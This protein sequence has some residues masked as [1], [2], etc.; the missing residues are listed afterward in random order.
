MLA[1]F[2]RSRRSLNR[3]GFGR[4]IAG[5]LVAGSL[6]AAWLVWFL[7]VPV[8][9]Y[10][11]TEEARIEADSSTHVLQAPVAGRVVLSNL[12]LG[13]E[14]EAGDILVAIETDMQRLQVKEE[15]ARAAM[16]EAEWRAVRAQLASE[17]QSARAETTVSMAAVGESRAQ[18]REAEAQRAFA[19]QEAER[20]S[21]LRQQ[22]LVAKRE[23]E[24]VAAGARSRRAAAEALTLATVRLEREQRRAESERETIMTRLRGES[25]RLQA[26]RV[27][28]LHTIE[29]LR[30][31][32]SRRNI[33]APVPGRLGE[34][35]V[36]RVGAFVSEGETLG[37]VVPRGRLRIVAQFTP[38][39]A[40]G[41]IRPGQSAWM[42]LAGFP[43]TQYGALRA[44]VQRVGHEVR[45]G[46]VRVELTVDAGGGT[47]APLQHGLPGTVE[48]QTE[49]VT[50]A[51]L[52]LRTAGRLIDR[53][54]TQYQ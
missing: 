24:R 45:N 40:L 51:T 4:S 32:V 39:A 19:D 47:A 48:V 22:G 44:T 36:L 41:R 37:A 29:R 8:A 20:T 43:W 2:G 15:E 16:L 21:R 46:R 31:E 28:A 30:F 42:R 1:E 35:G 33:V 9:R 25:D 54:R 3:D 49:T 6:L 34:V 13:R 7:T 27:T 23:E 14:V 10:E 52:A 50:A 12:T 18:F 53:P 5:V 38:P 26:A 11:V 17:A